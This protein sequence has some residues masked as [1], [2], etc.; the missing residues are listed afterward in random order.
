[1]RDLAWF[2][3]EHFLQRA[4]VGSLLFEGQFVKDGD[5]NIF[6]PMGSPVYL[7]TSEG[8]LKMSAHYNG[9]AISV[10]LVT[11]PT[12][13][14]YG[15]GWE[16]EESLGL[17]DEPFGLFGDESDVVCNRVRCVL[18][19]APAPEHCTDLIFIEM[20]FHG[21]TFDGDR[22]VLFDP[23]STAGILV[24]PNLTLEA[25]LQMHPRPDTNGP[26]W[27]WRRHAE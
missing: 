6:R 19:D 5:Y 25:R 7:S 4:E 13:E 14:S 22:V 12:W 15:E 26:V 9:G 20:T 21:P 17:V 8:L 23:M 2:E 11:E 3:F 18:D 24:R 16:S 10:A 27:E 1:M